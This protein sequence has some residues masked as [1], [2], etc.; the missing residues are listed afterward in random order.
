MATKT[1]NPWIRQTL[2]IPGMSL[3]F[4]VARCT[5][6]GKQAECKGRATAAEV[7]RIE[8]RCPQHDER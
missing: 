4:W 8:P 3:S 5:V 2:R 1:A 7:R 6:C